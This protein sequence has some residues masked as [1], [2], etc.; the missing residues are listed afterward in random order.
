MSAWVENGFLR[1]T[2]FLCVTQM[3]N[4]SSN[5]PFKNNN[6]VEVLQKVD[7]F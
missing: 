6:L 2:R 5:F 1:E 3:P 4:F 7:K